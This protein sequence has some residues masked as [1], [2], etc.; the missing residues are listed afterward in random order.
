MKLGFVSAILDGWSFE[1]MIDTAHDLATPAWRRPA[2][3]P[4]RPSAVTRGEPHRRGR[5]HRREGRLYPGLLQGAGRGALL[6]G[7]LP[8]HHGRGS[9]EAGGQHRP[10]EEGHPGQRE[11]GRGHGH[12]LRGPGHPQDRGGK[13]GAVPGDLAPHRRLCRGA[14]RQG[15][16]R[17]LPHVVRRHQLAR[18]PEPVHHPR[19]LAQV[20]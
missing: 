9:G 12:H 8:Q 19:H 1:E 3:P 14:P 16:H 20:L 11:A 2:G 17:E 4:A 18:R 5:P 13:P 7:L 10:S 15:G 6:P